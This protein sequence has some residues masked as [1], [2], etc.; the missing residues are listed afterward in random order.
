[1]YVCVCVLCAYIY[2]CMYACLC[3]C[4]YL[5]MYTYTYACLHMCRYAGMYVYVC[6]YVCMHACMCVCVFVC[7][8]WVVACVCARVCVC[9]WVCVLCLCLCVW[10]R[11]CVRARKTTHTQKNKCNGDQNH[12]ACSGFLGSWSGLLEKKCCLGHP[13][14]HAESYG[15]D[16]TSLVE[17]SS[18]SLC[19]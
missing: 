14:V 4:M 1:M 3:V 16:K 18:G 6:M 17:V 5:C 8:V 9:V 15:L 11:A 2:I 19:C 10:L 7:G 12:I 13:C